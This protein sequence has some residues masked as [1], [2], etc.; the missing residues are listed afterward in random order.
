AK[1]N[2]INP[3]VASKIGLALV[4]LFEGLLCGWT[5]WMLRCE[6][7]C[8]LVDLVP[9]RVLPSFLPKV[10]WSLCPRPVIDR[11]PYRCP[12]RRVQ[13]RIARHQNLPRL[14]CRTMNLWVDEVVCLNQFDLVGISDALT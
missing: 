9:P 1:D 3:L 6:E 2:L 5:T 8:Q 12:L 4:E 11:V 13:S 10:L 14:V 7:P